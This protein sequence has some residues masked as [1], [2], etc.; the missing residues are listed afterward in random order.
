MFNTSIRTLIIVGLL[1]GGSSGALAAPLTFFGMDQIPGGIVPAGGNAETARNS[2]LG[3]LTSV[4]NESFEG[5]AL[6][7]T[8]PI[9]LSFPGSNGNLAATLNS[10]Q[11]VVVTDQNPVGQFSTSGSQHLDADFGTT[12]TIDFASTPISAFGFYGTDISDSGGDLVVDIIDTLNTLTSFTVVLDGQTSG[13][14]MFWGFVDAST[15]YKTV[16][17]RNTSSSDRFGFDDMVI[18]DQQQ[19]S[20]N[21]PEPGTL[22]VLGLGLLGFAAA[23]RRRRAA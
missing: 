9:V 19:V 17:I 23:R 12:L 2:F 1:A 22:A 6:G 5:L 4:G 7:T 14:V 18:G 21:V 20:V 15:A 13:N 11:N 3:N 10:S 8:P 16:V